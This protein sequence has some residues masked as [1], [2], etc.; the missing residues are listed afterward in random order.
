MNTKPPCGIDLPQGG[1][2]LRNAYEVYRGDEPVGTAE[3]TRKGL[4]YC[5]RLKCALSGDVMHKAEVRCNG[6]REDL[7]ILVPEEGGFVLTTRIPIKRIGAGD[8]TFRVIPRHKPFRGHFV[9]LS[10]EEPF[11]YLKRLKDAF[12]VNQNGEIGILF[13][14]K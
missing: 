11:T 2:F 5:I 13:K 7:G 12:L 10:P 6:A 8:M 4:Y 14:Q 9:K 1:I 3:V